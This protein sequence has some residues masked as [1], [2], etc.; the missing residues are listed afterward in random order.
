MARFWV[1][2]SGWHYAHWSG[3]FYPPEMPARRWLPYY[4]ERFATVELN[5]SFYREPR[6]KTWDAWRATVPAGFR[7][8][9]KAHRFLTHVKRLADCED[10]LERVIK[11]ARHMQEKLGPLLFQLPPSFLRTDENVRRLESFLDLLPADLPCAFEFRHTSWFVSET[12]AQLRRHGTAFC[13]YDMADV[14]CPLTTTAAFAYMRFHGSVLVYHGNYSDVMLVGWA[15]RLR[16]LAEDLE[17]A[18]V[19]F[20][21]DLEGFAVANALKL[22]ELLGVPMPH[23]ALTA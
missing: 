21:N 16:A 19:Y 23:P 12:M 3:P 22:A 1:G 7:F 2:T 17:E 10:S 9:V 5:A 6:E 11:D 14:D 18:Y 13:S 4:A 8:A 20:N 15:D